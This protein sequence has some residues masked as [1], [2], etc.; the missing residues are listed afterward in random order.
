V[1]GVA[2]TKA[3]LGKITVQRQDA[4]GNPAVAPAAGTI[5]TLSSSSAGTKLFSTMQNSAAA[6]PVKI[7]AGA[8]SIAF[9]FGDTKAGSPTISVSSIGLAGATQP[10]TVIA[11]TPAKVKFGQQP[12]NRQKGQLFAPAITAVIEDEFGNQATNNAQVS[13]AIATNPSDYSLGRLSGPLVT[14]AV[15]GLATFSGLAIVGTDIPLP[16]FDLVVRDA[17]GTGNGY[18]LQLQSGGLVSEPSQPF[19]IIQ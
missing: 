14:N 11:A 1:A 12:T 2:S 5:L 4:Y 7:P 19:N 3:N 10:Q 13:I 16:I 18:K 8:D 9:Y 6:T 15:G 17:G